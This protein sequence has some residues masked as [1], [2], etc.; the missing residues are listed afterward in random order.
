MKRAC[1]GVPL[2]SR[3]QS[4]AAA[5]TL[6]TTATTKTMINALDELPCDRAEATS[7]AGGTATCL[8]LDRQDIALQRP[9][10]EPKR[11]AW[12]LLGEP[13][14][15]RTSPYQEVPS[16]VVVRI[17]TNW[18]GQDSEDHKCFSCLVVRFGDHVIDVVCVKQDVVH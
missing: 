16:G 9:Q 10:G 6:G 11:V 13:E 8:A 15:I 4:K 2:A 3:G 5:P 7:S 12:Y 1:P 17:D 18:T 14:L